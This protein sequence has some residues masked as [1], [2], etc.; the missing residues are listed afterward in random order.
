MTVNIPALLIDQSRIGSIIVI[1]ANDDSTMLLERARVWTIREEDLDWSPMWLLHSAVGK[2]GFR[3]IAT[4]QFDER[5][6]VINAISMDLQDVADFVTFLEDT[7]VVDS[8]PE[9]SVDDLGRRWQEWHT[10]R[11]S[12]PRFLFSE[13]VIKRLYE[14][15]QSIEDG[16]FFET[17]RVQSLEKEVQ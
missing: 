12:S 6:R 1:D 3:W 13:E 10:H 2:H 17:P 11:A 9:L 15:E 5:G 8:L 14:R 16:L 7:T 4:P